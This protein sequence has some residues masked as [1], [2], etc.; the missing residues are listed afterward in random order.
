MHAH[1]IIPVKGSGPVGDG[2]VSTRFLEQH[3]ADLAP[4]VDPVVPA[5][6]AVIASIPRKHAAPAAA[7]AGVPSVWE[8]L[9]PWGRGG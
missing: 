5:L 9:G 8:T 2:R 7:R 4:L 3:A 1:S 6:A